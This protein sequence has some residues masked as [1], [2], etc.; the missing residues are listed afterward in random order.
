MTERTNQAT[1]EEVKWKDVRESVA[2]V[3]PEFAAVIDGLKLN[4][5]HRLYK[6][7][8]PFGS[9]IV[10]EGMFYC[11]TDNGLVV[12]I[13]DHRISSKVRED[14]NYVHT[15]P[16]AIVLDHSVELFMKLEN[17][18]I[19]FVFITKGRV[20]ALWRTLDPNPS[21]SYHSGK[22]WHMVSG[23]R[24]IFMLPKITDK[25]CHKKLCRFYNIKYPL[26][27]HLL[28]HQAIFSHIAQNKNFPVHWSTELLFFS[29]EWLKKYDTEQWLRFRYFLLE[30]AWNGSQF[31]RN[32]FIFDFMWDSFVTELGKKNNMIKPYIVD[33]VKHLMMIGLGV[34]PGFS[35]ALD[36]EY[37]PIKQLQENFIEI[38]GLKNFAPIIMV[39]Y[40]FNPNE[41]SSRPVY[42]S[43]QIP[44]YF[45]SMPK[46]KTESSIMED[47][48]DIKRLLDL[49]TNA[50]AGNK[51]KGIIGT[52]IE[53][54]LETIQ[55]DYFHSDPDPENYTRLA[56][57]IPKEDPA[58]THFKGKQNKEFSQVS[59]FVRGCI[60]ISHK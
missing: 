56:S 17:G 50:V 60:R 24:N 57:E 39:P 6:A 14:L 8:Y 36:N 44:N 15:N 59:P 13:E 4:D 19:P 9:T 42:W 49:F 43:L 35:P 31:W 26:P 38:Y 29:A 48:R 23:A 52:P 45:R 2:K 28:D 54:C 7:R 33:I 27:Q 21:L 37:A 1:L 30:T 34:L 25:V 16:P 10:K 41:K 22:E 47:M 12:P 58:F 51:I 53:K 11:P 46:P 18:V 5:K 40:Y 3:K 55:F 32:K 20:F